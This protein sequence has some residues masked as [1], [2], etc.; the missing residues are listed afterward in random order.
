MARQP[1]YDHLKQMT[2]RSFSSDRPTRSRSSYRNQSNHRP[3][4][5]TAGQQTILQRAFKQ[6]LDLYNNFLTPMQALLRGMP[7]FYQELGERHK[8][9]FA[10]MTRIKFDIRSI[11]NRKSARVELP[12]NLEQY[13]DILFG[14]SNGS[15]AGISEQLAIFW[16]YVKIKQ[17]Y[18][19]IPVNVWPVNS[20]NFISTR[21]SLAETSRRWKK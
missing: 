8:E 18:Y 16:R 20:S 1:K 3:I 19:L 11:F 21:Q 9:L 2:G 13:R 6:E 7:E 17:R 10:Q 4:L 14:I 12:E 5:L 15:E